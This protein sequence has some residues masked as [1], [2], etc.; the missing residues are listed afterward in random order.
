MRGLC[1]G[2][3]AY[4]RSNSGYTVIVEIRH[5]RAPVDEATFH[6]KARGSSNIVELGLS[7]IPVQ[8]RRL[9]L[10]MRFQQVDMA[11]EIVV[12]DSYPHAPHRVATRA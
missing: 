4:T 6:A 2:Y 11:V 3:F 10:E 5:R 9:I 7:V 1:A 12:T 8:S